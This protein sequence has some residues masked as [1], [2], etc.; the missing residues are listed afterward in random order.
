MRLANL[1]GTFTT[2]A[3]CC[4]TFGGLALLRGHVGVKFPKVLDFIQR[5]Q[6]DFA[7]IGRAVLPRPN[8]PEAGLAPSVFQAQNFSSDYLMGHALNACV[9]QTNVDRMSLLEERRA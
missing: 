9:K 5:T 8:H 1:N 7:G 4:A 6:V 2:K 3:W